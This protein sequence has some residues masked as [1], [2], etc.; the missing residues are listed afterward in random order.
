[1]VRAS[2][3]IEVSRARES[4]ALSLSVP[5]PSCCVLKLLSLTARLGR[6]SRFR[7]GDYNLTDIVESVVMTSG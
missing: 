7:S 4:Y 1:M 5:T 6:T 2:A 3:R